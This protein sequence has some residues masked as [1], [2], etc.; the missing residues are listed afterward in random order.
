[1][2][3]NEWIIAD[4]HFLHR[5]IAEYCGRPQGFET[6]IMQ[7]LEVVRPNDILIHLGDLEFGRYEPFWTWCN[8]SA[9]TKV[10]IRGNHDHKSISYYMERGFDFC[11]DSFEL[12]KYGKHIR[13]SHKP[14]IGYGKHDVNIHGHMH[15][16]DHHDYILD[17]KSKLISLEY[18]NYKP[19]LLRSLV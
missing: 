6:L 17:E 2:K 18:N 14:Y 4:T 19:V 13:F 16:D 10:L 12:R 11:C 8:W 3:H 7:N 9:C 1:M 15:N 5:K